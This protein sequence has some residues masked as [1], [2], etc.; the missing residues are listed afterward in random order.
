MAK[1]EEVLVA[2]LDDSKA[3]YEDENEFYSLEELDQLENQ[4]RAYIARKFGYL[5]F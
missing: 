1:T 4:T 3:E 5:G 2:E